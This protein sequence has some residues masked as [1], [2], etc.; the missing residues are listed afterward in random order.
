[1]GYQGVATR[2]PTEAVEFMPD[3]RRQRDPFDLDIEL[4]SKWKLCY[5]IVR[6]CHLHLTVGTAWAPMPLCLG[7]SKNQG[8]LKQT[9][10][11]KALTMRHPEKGPRIYRNSH[12][13]VGV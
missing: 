5:C 1:M 13:N 3:P 8:A 4:Q 6:T 11:S 7:V 2:V 9:P 12:L 10:S